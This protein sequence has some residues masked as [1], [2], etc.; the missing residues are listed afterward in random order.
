[1]HYFAF[2]LIQMHDKALVSILETIFAARFDLHQEKCNIKPKKI[3]AMPK[4][5]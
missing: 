3:M 1:M 4:D 5:G 2:I